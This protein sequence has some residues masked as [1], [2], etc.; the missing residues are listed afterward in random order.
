M[1]REL[2][3]TIDV[4]MSA[5][6]IR[7]TGSEDEVLKAK[8]E[9]LEFISQL[10]AHLVTEAF[11]IPFS[12]ISLLIGEGGETIKHITSST[13]V[14]I[15]IQ[16]EFSPP[17]IVLRGNESSRAAAV[18]FI[19]DLLQTAGFDS[20]TVYVAIPKTGIST[21]AKVEPIITP[22]AGISSGYYYNIPP[23]ASPAL[24]ARLTRL[25]V[26]STLSPSALRRL[27][28]KERRKDDLLVEGDDDAV[29]E[30]DDDAVGEED[31]NAV[32][33]GNEGDDVVEGNEEDKEN[34]SCDSDDVID[35][36]LY[37]SDHRNELLAFLVAGEEQPSTTTVSS[38]SFHSS[39]I[40][41]IPTPPFP[42]QSFASFPLTATC[43]VVSSACSGG[44]GRFV[45][46][47]GLSVRLE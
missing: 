45:S 30:E 6:V 13:G 11:N 25:Q 10:T 12:A 28:R 33:E 14:K 32:G 44:Q 36:K 40:A 37:C 46:K 17:I 24:A 15:D 23:G 43:A 29:G 19:N 20:L 38:N 22:S 4:D 27:R 34:L 42:P 31:E 8:T 16:R 35:D 3:A 26:E 1:R 18:T 21:Q 5:C 9:I 47:S 39:S 7:V 2:C 41:L